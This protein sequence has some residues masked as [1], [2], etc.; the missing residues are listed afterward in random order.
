MVKDNIKINMWSLDLCVRLTCV[1]FYFIFMLL[2][3]FNAKI[4]LLL[5]M[6]LTLLCIP[7]EDESGEVGIGKVD[8][9]CGGKV[10]GVNRSPTSRDYISGM[11]DGYVIFI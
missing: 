7:T 9:A 1:L 10:V 6:I 4:I 11:L 8:M 3:I 2:S 5:Y